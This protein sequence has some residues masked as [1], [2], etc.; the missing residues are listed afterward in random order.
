MVCTGDGWVRLIK[1]ALETDGWK[2]CKREMLKLRWRD[3]VEMYLE[4]AR[5]RTR[6]LAR[7][8]GDRDRWRRNVERAVQTT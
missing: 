6:Q 7:L 4:K 8:A 2:I 1:S 5:V 3:N